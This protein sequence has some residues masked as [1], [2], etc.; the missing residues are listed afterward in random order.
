MKQKFLLLIILFSGFYNLN[1]KQYFVATNGSSQNSGSQTAPFGSIMQAQKVVMPGDTVYLRGGKYQI[2]EEQ[3]TRQI[4]IYACVNNIYK[5]G[6]KGKPIHYWAFPGEKPVFD[7][8]AVKPDNLRVM[9]FNVTGSWN[10]FK[11]FEIIGVQVTILGH[12][13]SECIHNEGSNNI[14]ENLSMH[15]GQGI[16]FYLTQGADNLILNCDAFN[17]WDFTSEGGRGGNVDGFGC[18]PQP[19]STGNIFRGCRAWFNSDDGYD[20]IRAAE[21]VTFDHCW[22]LYNGFKTDFSAL[23]DGN[24]FKAGGW[25]LKKDERV[26]DSIAGHK[27]HFC[28]AVGNR[29]NGF[30]ANHHPAGSEW[31]NNSAYKNGVN[32]NMLNRDSAFTTD[33]P[34]YNHILINNLAYNAINSEIRNLNPFKCLLKNNTFE[35]KL[36]PNSKDFISLEESQLLNPRKSNG[37]LPD[38]TFLKISKSSPL[39]DKGAITEF[40]YKGKAPE[41]G[42]TE[43]E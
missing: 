5:S 7:F 36:A 16:G 1:A 11:G 25:G 18:H 15:D 9:G 8:S 17:N 40:P 12:T 31:I 32:F 28:I 23:G 27:I 29:A 43:T 19:G 35:L 10:H 21:T 33:V 13:Q 42:A 30:Y 3:I 20:C 26:P 14:Y 24:G 38:I 39:I 34:G 41:P 37:D 2:T 6:S 4:R 22:S